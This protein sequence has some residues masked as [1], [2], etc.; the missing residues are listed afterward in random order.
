[1]LRAQFPEQTPILTV[2]N[3]IDLVD[4]DTRTQ[5]EQWQTEQSTQNHKVLLISA[6][7]GQG[8]DTLRQKLLDI[9]GWSTITESPWL[10]RE[11]HLQA[12]QRCA[13]HLQL[14]AAH[15]QHNDQILDLFAEELRLA[16]T[17]LE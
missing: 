17:E 13:E 15:A 6:L 9:A 7:T 4:D 10:A 1:E 11:R 3:K 14:A 2:C 12:L 16:H 8:L 5:L